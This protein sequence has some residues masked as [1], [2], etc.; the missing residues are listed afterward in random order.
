MYYY[1]KKVLQCSRAD[2]TQKLFPLTRP[3]TRSFTENTIGEVNGEIFYVALN[4]RIFIKVYR[5][6][7]FWSHE[8]CVGWS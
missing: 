5:A 1:I 8:Y 2:R 7:G 4:N 3:Q 6:K